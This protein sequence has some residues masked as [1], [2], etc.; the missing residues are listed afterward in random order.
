MNKEK[1]ILALV[2][3]RMGSKRFPGKMLK[4][5]GDKTIL[6]W[7]LLRTSSSKLIDKTILITS[8]LKRD[9]VL[10]DISNNLKISTFRGS[11]SDVLDRFSKAADI[12]NGD[13]IVRICADNP[14]IDGIEIDRLIKFYIK[15]NF[16]YCFNNQNKLNSN[17]ADGFGAEILSR[18][19]LT[20]LDENIS[21]KEEREHVTLALFKTDLNFNISA[22]K[23]PPALN[24]PNLRFDVD[25]KEDL[26]KLQKLVNFGVNINSSASDIIKISNQFL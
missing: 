15:N 2:Q 23:A 11:E 21:S 9:D 26:K 7:V 3:A 16:D 20:F 18:K 12:Y 25:V 6:E 8:T 10:I 19:L 22:L 5:L 13:F 24:F 17:Y 4:I 1:K 14:F